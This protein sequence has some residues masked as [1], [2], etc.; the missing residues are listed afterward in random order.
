MRLSGVITIHLF[1]M[2]GLVSGIHALALLPE[3]K[4]W[5]AETSPAM[6]SQP[7]DASAVA[8]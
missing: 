7:D 3:E 1:V 4:T 2:A 8:H 6:T 5:M